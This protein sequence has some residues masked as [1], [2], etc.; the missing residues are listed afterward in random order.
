MNWRRNLW[1]LALSVALSSSSYTM[2]V[3]FLPL[4]LL[5]I[6][7]SQE[8]VSLWSGLVFS[9]SFFMAAIM[10]PI[11]GRL[12]DKSGKRR[13]VIRAGYSLAIVYFLGAFVT[14]PYQLLVVRLLQ[15]FASGF[16]P[17]SMS[18]VAS[19]AP[20]KY[21]GFS[22]GLMQTGT[23]IGGIMGPLI[24]GALSHVFGMRA[25]FIIAAVIIGLGTVGVRLLVEEPKIAASRSTNSVLDDLKQALRDAKLME[26]LLLLLAVQAVSMVLQPLIALYIAQL[27]VS[28]ENV[29]L[30]SG[31]VFSLAGIAGAVAAPLW[32]RIGQRSGFRFIL[33]IAFFGAGIF[34]LGQYFARD[35][36]QFAVLQFVYGFFVVGAYPAI[37]TIAVSCV[38]EKSKG[39]VFGLTTTANSVG[40]M[41][42]PL[43]GGFISS[44]VGIRS[45]FLFTG[46]MLLLLGIFV[47][48]KRSTGNTTQ[49]CQ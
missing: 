42:G 10:A 43:L 37:N 3:P 39:R 16:V 21:M 22:L 34:N 12:A 13:M 49:K 1:V 18:I 25:S 26:M 9:I 33:M 46:G 29:S 38:D 17:A 23:L 5:D 28:A 14:N 19:T 40:S 6:G 31:I 41:L 30:V 45:V 8:N 47:L 2:V 20:Q 44:W 48:W 32:G 27:Q 35:V 7:V 24:G 15:G 11:W 4:Y 36:I